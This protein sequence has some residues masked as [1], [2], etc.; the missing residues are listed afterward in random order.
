MN[1]ITHCNADV[2]RNPDLA[3]NLQVYKAP[4]NRAPSGHIGPTQRYDPHQLVVNPALIRQLPGLHPKGRE[5]HAACPKCGGKDRF[6]TTPKYGYARWHCR[7]CGHSI[8][9]AALLGQAWTVA[10]RPAVKAAAT[11]QPLTVERLAAIRDLYKALATYAQAQIAHQPHAQTYLIDAGLTLD[12]AQ[13]AG[14]GFIDWPLYRQWYNAQTEEQ[15]AA[16]QWAGLPDGSKERAT[17]FAARFASGRRGKLLFPYYNQ[18]GDVVDQRTRSISPNDTINGKAIR[19]MSP[20]GNN[21]ER[22]VDAPYGLPFLGDARRFVLTE[23]EKKALVPMAHGSIP[24]IALRGT[25]DMQAAYLAYFRN[26]VAILAFDNDDQPQSHGLTAGQAATVKIGRYL[27]AHDISVMVLNPAK[28]RD[29]KGL[30][31]FVNAY[32]IEAFEALLQPSELVTLAEFEALFTADQLAHFANP[33]AD[34]GTVRQWLPADRVDTF[35]HAE[36]P[37]VT[38]AEAETQIRDEVTSH[39]TNY[40]RGNEQL[41]ITAPA[42]VGK[43]TI[44]IEEARAYAKANDK[45]V[46]VILPNHATIDEKITDGTLEGFQHIYGHNADNCRQ[47]ETAL[48]LVKQGYSPSGLICPKCPALKWCYA[49]GYKSQFK[50]KQDRAYV[51]N[52]LFSDY[53]KSE[54]IVIV[55]E[56]THKAFL[57]GK[58]IWPGDLTNALAKG[59]LDQAQAELLRAV[60]AMFTAPAL[61]D[62]EGLEFYEVLQRFYPS[63]PDVDAWGDGSLVQGA[64]VDIALE[65]ANQDKR[66]AYEAEELPQNFGEKLFTLLAEDV[67]RLNA[68]KLPTGRV[69]LVDGRSAR[70][71]VLTF[72]RGHLPGWYG[73]RPTIVLNATADAEIMQDLIGP[74]KVLAPNVAIAQGNEVIQDV[75]RNNAKSAYLGDSPNAQ[76]RRAQWLDDIRRQIAQH[77]GG[78]S[79]TV[80]IA[81]KALTPYLAET[82]PGARIAHYGALEGRN[83]L[84]AG[85]TILATAAPVNLA[86]IQHEAAA[87][88]P[89]IDLTLTRRTVAFDESNAGGEALTIEQVDGADHRL[90][91]LI[92]QHR[93]A[94]VIQAVHRA[95]LIRQTGRKVVV[96]FSRPIPGLKPT[97]IIRDYPD[98]A[99]KTAQRTQETKA[100]LITAAASLLDDVR[101]FSVESLAMVA[102]CSVNTA[103]KYFAEVALTLG[104]K[105]FDLPVRQTLANGGTAERAYRVALP[106]DL[107]ENMEL[108]VDHEHYRDNLITVVI[109]VQSLLPAGWTVI[110]PDPPKPPAPVELP[111]LPGRWAKLRDPQAFKRTL[112][113]AKASEDDMQRNAYRTALDW[114]NGR[115]DDNRAILGALWTMGESYAVNWQ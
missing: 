93:D 20:F 44:T 51:T 39:L 85:L 69:R 15:R 58:E 12:M 64:L 108:H 65:F 57:D 13:Q 53:P 4:R 75:T 88:Y 34:P 110:I 96:M 83:D 19:Y 43:T 78:E 94:A 54:D 23:G 8:T 52:H 92:W 60:L 27:R 112:M 86:A 3:I 17:G 16:C 72:G 114:F 105:W 32:G 90:Q 80:L 61:G 102:D 6:L 87:L 33:K 45:T 101:G 10:P 111:A 68:G 107:L 82:F 70:R 91:R 109:Y 47:H 49:A 14:I 67:R 38:L 41:L 11:E 100:K 55:D 106:A 7:Q 36:Q 76:K 56:L 37:T 31:D 99:T 9:T 1:N 50:D 26:R 30:D 79:D 46:A 25:D 113:R 95:R 97:A 42:G 18:S 62:L 104:C 35:A 40:R 103:R 48:A 98:Q 66:N 71:L 115:T 81:A 28:L 73:R 74:V 84:Q 59:K 89:G 5:L 21:T 77:P 24:V 2:K 29:A 22:G 63:L